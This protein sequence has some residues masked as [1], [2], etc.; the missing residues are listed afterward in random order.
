[1]I[2]ALILKVQVPHQKI[3]GSTYILYIKNSEKEQQHT[4]SFSLLRIGLISFFYL[5][6]SESSIH[7]NLIATLFVSNIEGGNNR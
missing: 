7:H 2:A 1:V 6:L 4:Y 3:I 5:S